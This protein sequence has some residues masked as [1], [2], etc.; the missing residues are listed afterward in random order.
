MASEMPR[1][2]I[3]ECECHSLEHMVAVGVY[4]WDGGPPDF[5]LEVT[6]DNHLPWYQRVWPA[7]KYLF[8]QPSLKWHDVLL[9]PEDVDRLQGCIDSYRE[10]QEIC[11]RNFDEGMS[12][13]P[14]DDQ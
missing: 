7:I 6:A 9:K 10:Q 8:G 2:E 11:R 4:D 5:F 3:F 13:E 14:S 12:E 1:K